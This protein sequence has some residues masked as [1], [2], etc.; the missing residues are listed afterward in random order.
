MARIVGF[1]KSF[2]ILVEL[3]AKRFGE[4]FLLFFGCLSRGWGG[5]S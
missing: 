2:F 1:L 3:I 4:C 5:R